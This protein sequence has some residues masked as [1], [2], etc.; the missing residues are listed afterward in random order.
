MCLRSPRLTRG[1]AEPLHFRRQLGQL[2]RAL[3]ATWLLVEA[4]A[5]TESEKKDAAALFVRRRVSSDYDLEGDDGYAP[6]IDRVLAYEPVTER[7][8]V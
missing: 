8:I 7:A 5:D 4:S 6:L 3:H 1:L 2:V